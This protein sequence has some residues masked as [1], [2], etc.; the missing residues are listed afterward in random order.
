[1]CVF[2]A[3]TID[4]NMGC[5]K[6]FSVSFNLHMRAFSFLLTIYFKI[7]CGMGASLLTKPLMVKEVLHLIEN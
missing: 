6:P 1:M 3:K 2:M 7:H 4:V 5:P